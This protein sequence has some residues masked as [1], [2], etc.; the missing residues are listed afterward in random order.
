MI[1][2]GCGGRSAPSIYRLVRPWNQDTRL[3]SAYDGK[4][5]TSRYAD[6]VQTKSV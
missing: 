2:G 4:V 1:Y 5:W 3:I 6:K